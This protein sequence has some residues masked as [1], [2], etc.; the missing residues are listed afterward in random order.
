MGCLLDKTKE[1]EQEHR[2][3]DVDVTRWS[4]GNAYDD[5]NAG[6]ADC[7]SKDDVRIDAV[8]ESAKLRKQFTEIK[9]T[10]L[11]DL[12][13]NANQQH[14]FL[15]IDV[16]NSDLDYVGGHIKKCTNIQHDQFLQNVPHI[17]DQY[18]ATDRIIIHCMYSAHRGPKCCGLYCDALDILLNVSQCNPFDDTDSL[19]IKKYYERQL[20]QFEIYRALRDIQLTQTQFDNLRKQKVLLLDGGFFGFINHLHRDTIATFID[21]FDAAQWH[22][23][24]LHNEGSKLYHNN[25]W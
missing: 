8:L 14:G 13:N 22:E 6:K 20:Q 1:P 19:E 3:N 2:N 10:E 4:V 9:A 5:G 18:H 16:R 25:D 11:T 24:D 12:M 17:I 21:D 7:D 23:Q 15:V